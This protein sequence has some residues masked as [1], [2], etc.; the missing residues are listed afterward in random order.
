MASIQ[1]I[2]ST[3]TGDIAY[4]VQVRVKGRE[5]QSKTFPN[6]KEAEMWASSTEAAIREG[7]NFPHM[8]AMRTPFADVV[9]RYRESILKGTKRA[10]KY[11]Q[12]LEWWLNKFHGK[13]LG[14]ITS[15]IIAEARDELAAG[16]YTRAKPKTNREGRVTIPKAYKRSGST[17]NRYLGTL[18]HVF[19]VAM[20]EWRLV[21]RNPVADISKKKE[22]RGRV[23]FLSDDEREALLA[24]CERSDWPL[25]RPL[26]LLA[27][28]TGAR[29]SELI[30]LKWADVDLK[31]NRA[32][33]HDTKN[34]DSRVLPLVGKALEA[35]REVKLQNSARSEY[36]FP[37]PSG[38]PGPFVHFEAHWYAALQVAGIQNMRFH[39]LRH[40][41]ASYLAQQGASLLEIADTLGHRTMAMV[42]RYSHLAQSHKVSVI[43]KMAKNRGL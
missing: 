19:T 42:K 7:R 5:P 30:N 23:R 38:F 32:I 25:L 2:K 3:L 36:V 40:T 13:T 28:S 35:I 37:Q 22:S 41:T 24:A 14:E 34:G 12:H 4:R 9:A 33:V 11:D 31:Q 43:E 16:T 10:E 15:D 18:S 39:D 1:K 20:K 17:V 6:K 8:K 21:D 26:V 29:R 27:I